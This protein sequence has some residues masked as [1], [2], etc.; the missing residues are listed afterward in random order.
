MATP[1]GAPPLGATSAEL[2]N[3]EEVYTQHLAVVNDIQ[4]VVAS[5]NICNAQ[6]QLLVSKGT[7]IDAKTSERIL[8]F[9]LLKPI[10]DSI[11][12]ENQLTGSSLS[13]AMSE[14]FQSDASLRQLWQQSAHQLAMDEFC[15]RVCDYNLIAQ[16]LTVLQ[17]RYPAIFEQALFCAWFC[18][19]LRFAK[20][21]TPA[22][23]YEAFLAGICHDVGML[24][25]S[26]DVINSDRQLT[27][28]EWRQVHSHPVIGYRILTSIQG[29]SKS[30]SAAVL[31]H[32]ENLDGTGYPRH[33]VASQLGEL[34]KL[35]NLSDSINAIYRKHL[36]PRSRSLLDIVP[37]IQMNLDSRFDR[38]AN[39]A[40]VM[41]RQLQGSPST[42]ELHQDMQAF[43]AKLEDFKRYIETFVDTTQRYNKAIGYNHQDSRLTAL[44]NTLI[45]ISMALVQSGVID[46]VSLKWLN[47]VKQEAL[48]HAF[49]E[50]E[51]S[52]LMIREVFFHIERFKSHLQWYIDG[53]KS[54]KVKAQLTEMR[55]HLMLIPSLDLNAYTGWGGY[56]KEAS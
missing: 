21:R 44:Q 33:R 34:G 35:L 11:S 52:F 8:K 39:K 32:H 49:G 50:V 7:N 55:D 27:D 26:P 9:K 48:S 30:V 18:S 10:E 13:Q 1:A 54:D 47:H 40:I 37:I 36:K 17:L 22:E 24:H 4:G 20:N 53:V 45:H 23:A 15:S 12:I 29:F 14:L 31:E 51:Q 3:S 5:E 25:I 46:E 6:G 28:A 19:H 16:K 56:G 42:Q 2:E 38:T 41:L 43:I